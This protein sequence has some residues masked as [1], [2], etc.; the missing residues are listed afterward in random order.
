MDGV[1]RMKQTPIEEMIAIKNAQDFGPSYELHKSAFLWLGWAKNCRIRQLNCFAYSLWESD[2]VGVTHS[3]L[4]HEIEIKISR[5]DF[6]AD[7][8][9]VQKHEW[10]KDGKL[11]NYFWYGCPEALLSKEDIPPYAGL[12]YLY[13]GNT[14]R[15]RVI[16]P[17]PRIHAGKISNSIKE[18]ILHSCYYRYLEKL[19]GE[20]GVR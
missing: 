9:K 20:W 3:K 6:K 5:S 15:T 13:P 11:A 16:V 10:L 1:G 7:K 4:L 17:A 2:V 8:R 18:N 12:L 19:L 14:A